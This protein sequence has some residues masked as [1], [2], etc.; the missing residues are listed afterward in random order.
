M[1]ASFKFTGRSNQLVDNLSSHEHTKYE[2]EKCK[3]AKQM[4][5]KYGKT[6]TKELLNKSKKS[7]YK[8]ADIKLFEKQACTMGIP[9][10]NICRS[11]K[12]EGNKE[13]DLHFRCECLALS[14]IRPR[15]WY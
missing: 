15:T 11:C 7:I 13:T 2:Q 9:N 5:P 12:L 6:R 3:I 1:W 4:C 8:L 14:Q 10:N